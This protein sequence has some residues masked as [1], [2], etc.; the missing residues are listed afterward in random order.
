MCCV[1]IITSHTHEH[2]FVTF[3][4]LQY[5]VDKIIKSVLN[6]IK[7]D[8]RHDFEIVQCVSRRTIG[9]NRLFLGSL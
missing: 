8:L 9:T 7:I 6:D 4:R 5:N 2:T 1:L 3:V